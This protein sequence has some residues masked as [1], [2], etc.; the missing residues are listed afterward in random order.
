[1]IGR[2]GDRTVVLASVVSL[3]FLNRPKLFLSGTFFSQISIFGE[4]RPKMLNQ[5]APDVNHSSHV[6]VSLKIRFG[7]P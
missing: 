4:K 7:S 3:C 2:V 1:M 6:M 5:C